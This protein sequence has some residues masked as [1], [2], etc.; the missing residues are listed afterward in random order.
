[1]DLSIC[2]VTRNAEKPLQVC[3][4]S[5]QKYLI[6]LMYEVIVVDNAST[7]QTTQMIKEKFPNMILLENS[8]NQGFT[9]PLNKALHIATG[10]YLA[11]LNPDTLLIEDCFSPLIE[12][13]ESNIDAGVVTPKILN[14]DGTWQMQSRRGE[15]RPIEV[16]AYF[17]GI[18]KLFP[19]NKIL[20]GYLLRYLD[21]DS[22]SEVKAVSGSCMLIRRETLIDVNYFDE[23]FF[24][25]QEDS[26]FCLQARK[27]GWKIYYVP[28]TMIYHYGG[29]GGSGVQPYKGIFHWHYSYFLYYKKNLAKNYFFLFN[30]FFYLLMFVKFIFSFILN[31]FKNKKIVGTKK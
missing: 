2:I 30:C 9:S 25:Y 27:L 11:V 15:G 4:E 26:D 13:M 5:I 8:K 22:V 12:Y 1:M 29:K 17:T 18:D 28:G 6:N 24:A 19:S 7:D 14:G 21:Q 10:N 31:L 3:L 16:F 23:R 20:N